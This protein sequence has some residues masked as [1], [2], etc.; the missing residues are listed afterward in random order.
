MKLF[1]T[2]ILLIPSL[3]WGGGISNYLTK[4]CAPLVDVYDRAKEAQFYDSIEKTQSTIGQMFAAYVSGFN[5]A[6]KMVEL[7]MVEIQET[8][9]ELLFNLVIDGCRKNKEGFISDIIVKWTFDQ[10]RLKNTTNEL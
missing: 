7:E 6:R 9:P 1:L 3:S 10:L 5:I 4:D 8:S 2:L